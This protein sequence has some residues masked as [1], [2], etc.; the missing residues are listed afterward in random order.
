MDSVLHELETVQIPV[1]TIQTVALTAVTLV[2]ACELVLPMQP[3]EGMSLG[4]TQGGGY[5]CCTSIGL[6]LEGVLRTV[7][8]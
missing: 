4:K 1:S 7:F 8:S 6:A 5:R 2:R 3:S